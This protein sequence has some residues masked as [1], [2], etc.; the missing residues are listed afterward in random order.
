MRSWPI[1]ALVGSALFQPLVTGTALAADQSRSH[2]IFADTGKGTIK[3]AQSRRR[4]N[5]RPHGSRRRARRGAQPNNAKRAPAAKLDPIDAARYEA[6]KDVCRAMLAGKPIRFTLA[7]PR[8][9]LPCAIAAPVRVTRVA[10]VE[11]KPPVLNDCIVAVAL[12]AW[13]NDVVRP[14]ARGTIETK[15]NTIISASGYVCR[16]RNSAR[17]ARLSEH[18]FG[19]AID[20]SGFK[21]ADGQTNMWE[22]VWHPPPAQPTQLAK[23][24]KAPVPSKGKAKTSGTKT[25]NAATPPPASPETHWQKH[26][27]SFLRKIHA[28]ACGVFTTVLGPDANVYHRDHFHFDLASRKRGPYCH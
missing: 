10:G 4:S 22:T 25:G 16:T 21:L 13:I 12:L 17:G 24:E 6:G 15:I 8:E 9:V 7:P 26:T 20:I 27:S 3:L 19:R 18:A 5:Q 2:S 1:L 14:A 28:G 23:D 11:I